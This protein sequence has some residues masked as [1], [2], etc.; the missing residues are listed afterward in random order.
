MKRLCASALL[1]LAAACG[2]G[3][4]ST[5][6]T[7][8]STESYTCCLNGSFYDCGSS[9][10]AADKCFNNGNPGDCRRDSSRDN[11]CRS[12]TSSVELDGV[13]YERTE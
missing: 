3:G 11:G 12:G 1:A 6:N 2:S 10:A 13:S 5:S 8:T 7:N 9:R 4:G